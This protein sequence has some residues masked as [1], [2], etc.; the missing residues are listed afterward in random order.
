MHG[1]SGSLR[2]ERPPKRIAFAIIIENAGYGG[3]SAAPVA[4]EIV[5][6]AAQ[7]GLVQ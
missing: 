7:S 3:A 6:A 4:G 5:T 2:T 1:S